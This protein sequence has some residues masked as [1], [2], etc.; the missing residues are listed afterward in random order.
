MCGAAE[1][2]EVVAAFE[3]RHDAALAALFGDL[4]QLARHPGEI[5]FDAG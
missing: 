3:H 4:H 2:F 1:A 5:F